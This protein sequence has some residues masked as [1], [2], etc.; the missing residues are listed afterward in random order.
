MLNN[1][2]INTPESRPG[3]R[4]HEFEQAVKARFKRN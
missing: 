2:T 3:D 4:Y 1:N